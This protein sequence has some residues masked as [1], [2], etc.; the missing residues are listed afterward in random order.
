M[1][2]FLRGRYSDQVCFSAFVQASSNRPAIAG[3]VGFEADD[4][5]SWPV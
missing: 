3:M 5:R 4:L 2:Q 1:I